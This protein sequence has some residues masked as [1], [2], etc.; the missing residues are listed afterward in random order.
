[1]KP[2]YT[3]P[4]A[5]ASAR[6]FRRTES[7]LDVFLRISLVPLEKTALLFPSQIEEG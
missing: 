2:T 1:M 3:V 6:V 7:R 5:K 4:D